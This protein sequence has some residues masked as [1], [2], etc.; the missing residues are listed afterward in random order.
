M[1]LLA[2]S[3]VV[4][5]ALATSAAAQSAGG[6][7]ITPSCDGVANGCST[8]W[9]K[10]SVTVSFSVSGSNLKGVDCPDRT[11][12]SDT[13]G[14]DVSCVVTLTDN[15]IT[16]L[17]V[18]IK[19]DATPPSITAIAAARPPDVN[20]WY[21]HALGVAASGT[22]ATSGI[23]SC[24]SVTYGGPDSATASV[25]GTC[26]DNAGN[27]SA[28][29]TITFPYD[30][31]P[32]AV[33]PAPARSAD[34]NGWYN[35]PVSVAFQGSDG[36]SGLDSCTSGD[37][38]GPDNAAAAVTGTCRDKAGNTGTASF[39]LQY[40][41]TPPTVDGAAADRPPDRNGWYN[42]PVTVTYT[43]SDATSGIGACDS[44]TYGKPDDPT[45]S[46]SGRCED[47]AGNKSAAAPFSFRYDSSPPKLA[48]LTAASSGGAV[49][50]AW[51]AAAD[52]ASLKVERRAGDGAPVT[53]YS[54]KR[55]ERFVDTKARDGSR[56]A[57]SV[58]AA[59]AAGNA[60]TE[61]V[62]GTPSAALV[63]PRA[64]AHVRTGTT[65]RWR[66]AP[67]ATYYNVQLWRNG[68]KVLTTWPLHPVLP[69][70]R[71][72][73]GRYLW[74]VWPGYGARAAHRYGALLGKSTFVVG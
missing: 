71:L 15:S 73:P 60:T 11:I 65:L 17:V 18:T 54:G 16:G 62:V 10:S 51:S 27:V 20:G 3:A 66:P 49:T 56:Y 4:A 6:V 52:V 2:G 43:G 46:V 40:D 44:V 21:N 31:T 13:A 37:Y 63:A 39:A 61:K 74:L 45:A 42:R 32:P 12:S 8:G 68:T 36:V 19:R 29:K 5:V 23:A 47:K 9:Y 25:S 30:A 64:S 26:T 38:S 33:S 24:T 28:A 34:A 67:R 35:H 55:I 50:L 48:K 41:S 53:L 70:P 14:T 22:D 69:L 58:V 57:Y 72:R 59:D 1:R 7:S